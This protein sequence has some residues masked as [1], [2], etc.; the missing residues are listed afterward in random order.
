MVTL[1]QLREN[2]AAVDSFKPMNEDDVAR[3]ES[4]LDEFASIGKDFCTACGYCMD[5][6]NGVNIP[7][8]FRLYNYA[9]VYGLS[10]WAREHYAA[11][12]P[13]KRA[14]ACIRCGEC[15]PKCPNKIPIMD[16]LAQV[17]ELLGL[18]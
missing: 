16:Q 12:K 4:I 10:D 17:D 7:A 13:E 11:M 14:D 15:E 2:A 1:E 3:V 8:N 18:S 5:C 6:P 9:Q